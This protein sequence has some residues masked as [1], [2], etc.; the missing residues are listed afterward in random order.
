VAVGIAVVVVTIWLRV[1]LQMVVT[2]DEVRQSG[3]CTCTSCVC[4]CVCVR[5]V[6]FRQSH[7]NKPIGTL[8][9]DGVEVRGTDAELDKHPTSD[10]HSR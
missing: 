2:E 7:P 4:M 9:N 3:P 5:A 1:S 10:I 6:N 8:L